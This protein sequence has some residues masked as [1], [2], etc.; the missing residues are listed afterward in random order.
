MRNPTRLA[1][2]LVA[3]CSAA[4]AAPAAAQHA[5][6]A[7]R[8][9]TV[10]F[11]VDCNAQAQ[12]EF[13]LAMAYYHSFAWRHIDAPLQRVLQADPGC[14][15][16]HWLRALSLLDNPFTWPI[17]L[18][19]EVLRKAQTAL[20]QARRTGLGTQRERDYADALA[21]FV[22]DAQHRP[23]RARAEALEQAL[24][25]V[26]QQYP[27]DREAA[28]LH[29]LVMSANF[30]PADRQYTRQ[31]RAARILEPIFE[32]LP[33][34]PGVAHYLIHSYDYPPIA[35]HGLEAARRYAQIAPDSP[36][37]LHMPSHIFTRA[38]AWRDS[39][40]S[41]RDSAAAAPDDAF[42]KAHAYDYLV[43]AHT[44]LA[45][46]RAARRVLDELRRSPPVEHFAFAYA[47]A[48]IPARLALEREQ[49][50]DAAQLALWPSRDAY[51]WDKYPQAEAI[52]AFARGIGA[53]LSGAPD[54]ARDEVQRLN[55]LR[56]AMQQTKQRYWVEQIEIQAEVV[57][58][59]ALGAEGQRDEAVAALRRA[60]DREDA[61]QKHVVTP[62]PL[63]PAREALAYRLLA[64]GDA[65]AALREFEATLQREPN[66]YR[67]L[68][69]AAQAAERA[70]DRATAERYYRQLL[71]LTRDG[72]SQRPEIAQA[73]R[74]LRG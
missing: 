9:G 36:H 16:A 54:A 72:D 61:T 40:A 12:R 18:S 4:V 51:P 2:A 59:L 28:I 30:D 34:H 11:Q 29:A 31:L 63:V 1:A 17:P 22:V 53:A 42:D 24:G 15:M 68:A 62:G 7:P 74:F 5:G 65:A 38:G 47:A 56:D 3:A 14:G 49:W 23:H 39:V 6:H 44:Q 64:D 33:D 21:T 32:Q 58:G 13:N 52:H 71:E 10:Q 37:A 45:Q 50:R 27:E 66:R 8:L 67:T 70:A 48:A 46:D 43:Y 55:D 25:R 60:A 57:R 20:E 26:A 41:N 69:G 73:Q 19:D 35:H